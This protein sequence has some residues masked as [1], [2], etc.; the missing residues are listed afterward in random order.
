MPREWG[1]M[2][3]ESPADCVSEVHRNALSGINYYA[4]DNE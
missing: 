2:L 3:N 4:N 1:D